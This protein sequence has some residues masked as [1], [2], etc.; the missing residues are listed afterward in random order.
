MNV[1]Q[2]SDWSHFLLTKQSSIDKLYRLTVVALYFLEQ[3]KLLNSRKLQN[4]L[5][6]SVKIYLPALLPPLP[7]HSIDGNWTSVPT[8]DAAVEARFVEKAESKNRD[9]ENNQHEK[10]VYVRFA[11]VY[12]WTFPL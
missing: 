7:P 3:K 6:K 2:N 4:S 12:V 9:E 1:I 8:T 5:L 10:K 11:F